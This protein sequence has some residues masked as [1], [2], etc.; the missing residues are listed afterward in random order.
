MFK[1]FITRPVLATVCSV[2]LLILGILG[3]YSLPMSRFPD[4]APPTISVSANYPGA[5]AATVI[6]S[7][8]IPLEEAI[9]GAEKMRYMISSASNDGSASIDV[10]FE[11]GTNPDQA[12]V[13]VQNRVA[14]VTNRLPADVITSGVA[15]RKQQRTAL[16]YMSIYD[17]SGKYD[18]TFLQNYANINVVPVMQRVKGVG[19]VRVFG[20]KDYAMRIWLDP[21][22]LSSY[23]LSPQQVIAAIQEQ[24]IETAPGKLGANSSSQLEYVIKYAGKYNNVEDYKKIIIRT[25]GSQILYLEDIANVELGAANYDVVSRFDSYHGV[26]LSVLQTAGSNANEVQIALNKVLSEAKAKFPD[27]IKYQIIFNTKEHLDTS[28][29]QVKS[30]IIEAFILVFIIV[31]IFLQDFRSTIIPAIA[32]PVSLIGT[33]FFLSLFGFSIN[34]LTLFALVLAIGIVVDD[35]IVVVEAVHSKMEQENI[36]GKVA[37]IKAMDEITGAIVSITLVMVAVFFPVGFIQ[38]SVGE[39]YKQF[40]FTLAIAILISA[41][42]ALTLSPALC[43][44][45]LK[46]ANKQQTNKNFLQR[47]YDNFNKAFNALIEKYVASIRFLANKKII[48]IIT[49]FIIT[50]L[51]VVLMQKTPK[52]FI[53]SEDSNLVAYSASLSP[54]TSLYRTEEAI[55]SASKILKEIPAIRSKTT[56]AGFDALSGAAGS[57]Y[58]LSF[59]SLKPIKERGDV[60]EIN[61]VMQLMREKLSHVEQAKFNVFTFPTVPGFSSFNGL[62]LEL[63]D[64]RGG[65]I[66]ELNKQVESFVAQIS[67]EKEIGVAFSNFKSGFPQYELLVDKSAAKLRNISINTIL[68]TLQIYY[69]GVQAADFNLFSKFYRVYVQAKPEYRQDPESLNKIFVENQQGQLVPISGI[70]SL[71]KVYGPDLINRYNMFNS[72]TINALP[73]QGFSTGEAMQSIE[74]LAKKILPEGYDFEWTGMSKEEQTAGSQTVVIFMLS[75]LFVYLILSAKYESYILPLAVLLSLPVGIVGVFLTI[76]LAGIENNIYVQVGLIM[77]IG[78]L[79]KNAIL[80]IEFA[81]Q[82][83]KLGETIV[84]SAI[85]AAK[86][87][88]RPILMTSFAFIA[89]LI[90]LTRVIGPSAQGNKSISIG[91]I[92]GMLTGVILGVFIIPILFIVFQTIQEKLSK[93][94][95][96]S[97]HA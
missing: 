72:I 54:G 43:A 18:E 45:F 58:A 8:I 75:L 16:M 30:T 35:A 61:A 3:L 21:Q 34:M 97:S 76:N 2:V 83:R 89:G 40:A 39:F 55:E 11:L 15:T 32:V 7:V 52:G 59:M 81:S 51:M 88:L 67:K 13:D 27:G 53:P 12:A 1:I 33:F 66:D 49:L 31:F 92:G 85:S 19:N 93:I 87:R 10:L 62:E 41:F 90:P 23:N 94:F 17:T 80:I 86:L 64:K 57:S 46:H 96:K 70:V 77:L 42:N 29:E 56:V 95:S 71:K 44:V 26:T 5:D 28:I 38:G 50:T 37:T 25:G 60:Q 74:R 47:F 14:R 24:S 91:T 73:A 63:Q 78:L 82:H 84:Q 20:S 22:K 9:N 36:D 48:C 68:R 4:I 65:S 79:A 69:G 6:R